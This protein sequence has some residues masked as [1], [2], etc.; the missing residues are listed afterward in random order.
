MTDRT[1]RERLPA[2]PDEKLTP[3]Q[4]KIAKALLSGSRRS[5]RG[6]FVPMLR[7]PSLLEKA[8]RLGQYFRYRSVVPRKLRELAILATTRHWQQAYEWNEHVKTAEEAGLSSHAIDTLALDWDG[9]GLPSD[10]R[11]VLHFCRE[12]HVSHAVSDAIYKQ[13]KLLL[14]EDGLVELC[15]ICGYYALISMVMNVAR[16]PAADG[17]S[18]PFSRPEAKSA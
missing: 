7:S 3:A 16:T 4:R 12:L 14:G 11:T 1:F 5:L 8:Q 13:T 18:V 10:E 17:A 15:G 2:L 9:S 6:A